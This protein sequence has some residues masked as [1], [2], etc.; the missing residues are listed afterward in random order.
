MET[1]ATPD[2]LDLFFKLVLGAAT[3][4]KWAQLAAL[5][6]VAVVW[7]L[8]KFI[9]PKMP[10]FGTGEGGAVLTVLTSFAGAFATTLL[11]GAAFSWPLVWSSLQV[12]FLAA[13]GWSLAKHL[14]P[15]LMKVPFLAALFPPKS[16]G[17]GLVAE[18]QKIGLANAVAAKSPTSDELVNK[19]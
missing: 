13:G 7:A 12:A 14:L 2:Q 17:P 1:V 9:A 15:L 11:A 19:P 5:A 16:N 10:F 8:R 6:L 3:A 4:G 18:A